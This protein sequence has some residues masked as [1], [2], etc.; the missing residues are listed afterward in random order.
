M[1]VALAGRTIETE[2]VVIAGSTDNNTLFGVDLLED[3]RVVINVPRESWH[4]LDEPHR[5]RRYAVSAQ[6]DNRLTRGPIPKQPGAINDVMTRKR[7]AEEG[8]S[9]RNLRP[10]EGTFTI[11]RLFEQA[12]ATIEEVSGTL[13]ESRTNRIDIGMVDVRLRPRFE[14]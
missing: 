13:E 3:A 9:H 10:R 2:L 14:L 12:F 11:D 1:R 6:K 7:K 4:F 8:T 5:P